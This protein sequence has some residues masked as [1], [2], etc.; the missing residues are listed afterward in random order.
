MSMSLS[1]IKYCM[2]VVDEIRAVDEDD[3][4]MELFD[5]L[6]M[7]ICLLSPNCSFNCIR[8]SSE[9]TFEFEFII[10]ASVVI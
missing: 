5:E 8:I 10:R 6:R 3:A 1:T 4:D 7:K 2:G 9:T